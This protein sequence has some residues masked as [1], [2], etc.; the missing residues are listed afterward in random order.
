MKIRKNENND[1]AFSFFFITQASE[2]ELN[3]ILRISVLVITVLSTVIA[4]TVDSVYYLS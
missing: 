2:R 3:W 1:K 4:L